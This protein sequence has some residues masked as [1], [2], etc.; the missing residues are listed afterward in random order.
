MQVFVYEFLTG[1]GMLADLAPCDP[2]FK[3]EGRAMVRAVSEDLA[4]SGRC[5]VVIL[6]DVRNA[7]WAD[8]PPNEV[9]ERIVASESEHER[10]FDQLARE[11]EWTLL[12]A[13]ETN[14]ILLRL[15]FR[16][17]SLG[18]KL[19][20]PAADFISIAGDKWQTHQRL[21]KTGVRVPR[22]AIGEPLVETEVPGID[23]ALGLVVKPRDGAGS[24]GITRSLSDRYL[25]GQREL[26]LEEF[27]PGEAASILAI[28]GPHGVRFLPPFTQ[29]I[30]V[31]AG[32][33]YQGGTAIPPH[34]SRASRVHNIAALALSNLPP[35][36]GLVGVDLILGEAADG[37]LDTIIEVNPRVTTSY[38]GARALA[39]TNIAA[40]MLDWTA[41]Y[42]CTLEFDYRPLRFSA[43][44]ELFFNGE[45][46]ISRPS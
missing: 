11:S 39:R 36:T 35:F 22:S 38:V 37:S 16:V 26:L 17:E 21:R 29:Q 5:Q 10:Q 31:V 33:A 23:P 13:P 40:A 15:A 1:G 45:P 24:E 32:F 3:R 41:G 25:S 19:L 8:G 30:D 12:I 18:G 20:S 43:D 4:T 46:T 7:V 42:D 34:D 9:A 2:T 27:V 28:G 44:G 14:G 6:R